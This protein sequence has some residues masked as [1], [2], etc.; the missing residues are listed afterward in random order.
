MVTHSWDKIV[1]MSA[2]DVSVVDTY[3]VAAKPL[4]YEET[5]H[6][7]LCDFYEYII[8]NY[9]DSIPARLI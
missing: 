5:S 4:A 9:L 8:D 3:N 2:F 1:N 7:L 6:V